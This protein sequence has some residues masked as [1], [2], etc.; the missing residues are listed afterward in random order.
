MITDKGFVVYTVDV[1]DLSREKA[2]TFCDELLERLRSTKP[3]GWSIIVVPVRHKGSKV[4]VFAVADEGVKEIEP[5]VLETQGLTK[6]P[7]NDTQESVK[8]YIL[9]ML[10]VPILTISEEV[11]EYIDDLIYNAWFYEVNRP[12]RFVYEEIHNLVNGKDGVIVFKEGNE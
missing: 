4:Q 12:K 11:D 3:E 2:K 1:L 5:F 8:D 9:S 10:G 6:T 7:H